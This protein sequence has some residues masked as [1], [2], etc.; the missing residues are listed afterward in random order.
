MEIDLKTD[1]R[2]VKPGDTFIAIRNVNRDGHDYIPQAIKNGA[3]KV[4]VEEGNYDVETIVVEDTRAYLKDYLYKHYYPYFKDM[5]LIGV[6]GTNGKTTIGYMMYQMMT[7]LDIPCAYMGTIGFYYCGNFIKMVN[8]T[9]DVDVLYDYFIK[10]KDAG[11]K[12]LVMEV[13][14]HALAKDRI[15]GLEFDEVAFTNLTQDHLDFHKTLENF[16]NAKQLLFKKTRGNKIALINGDDPHA[17][18]FEL[19]GNH[20]L[21][22]S[23]TKGDVLIQNIEFSHLGTTFTFKY[24]EKEYQTHIQMVGRYN[25]YNYLTAMLLIHE[26][27][28]EIDAILALNTKLKAPKGRMELIVYGTNGI[29]VDYAHTPDA[30]LNVLESAQEFKKGRI[31]TIIGCGGDR[32]TTKRPIMGEIACKHS[33]RVIITDDNPRTEDPQKI[34]NDILKG[35]SGDYEVINDRHLA[36]AKGMS[37][38]KE[39]DILMILG[40]GHEDYQIIGT[41]KIHFSDQEEVEKYINQ[42][43]FSGAED[44]FNTCKEKMNE[45]ND[46]IGHFGLGF[47]SSFMVSKKVQIDTLSYKEN[48]TPVRWVS[49]DG[50]EFELTQSDNRETRGTTITLFLAD[51]SKEFLEEYTVRN[52]I[53]KYCSFLPVDIYLETIKTEETKEDE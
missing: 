2:K 51:D 13:S 33:D 14:S 27:G 34:I 7:M 52:I 12:V 44:F 48:A 35:V 21:L 11:C 8:T 5:K 20:N 9:P 16:A 24:Q 50:L 17:S 42:V 53:D 23:D 32:D 39:N 29:F 45:E 38:L 30:T 18:H 31:I 28:Y 22:I 41:E 43:A 19:E 37:L 15:H 25:V 6:T 46:I 36:I 47:Y 49:E 26:L 4:I 3:T 10:A 1:S 40:K